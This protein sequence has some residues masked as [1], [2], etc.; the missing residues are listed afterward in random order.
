MILND[1]NPATLYRDKEYT[2]I[3][4]LFYTNKNQF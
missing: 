1:L 4:K 2:I 3:L